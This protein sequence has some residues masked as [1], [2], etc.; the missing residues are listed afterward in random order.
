MLGTCEKRERECRQLFGCGYHG[1]SSLQIWNFF[2]RWSFFKKLPGTAAQ[3][4]HNSWKKPLAYSYQCKLDDTY[5]LWKLCILFFAIRSTTSVIEAVV[6][7]V[8]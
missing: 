2:K 4:L 1:G 6:G 8:R 5:P 3:H 7:T